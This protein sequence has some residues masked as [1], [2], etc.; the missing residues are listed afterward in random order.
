MQ[1]DALE[2]RVLVLPPTKADGDVTLR[3]LAEAGVTASVCETAQDMG[4]ELRRG[5]GALII[6]DDLSRQDPLAELRHL[7]DRQPSWSEI[8]ILVLARSD[9]PRLD[10][11]RG[12]RGVVLL[13]RPV[14][15]RSMVSA[16]QAALRP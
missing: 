11:L 4:R 7:L 9:F 8:P 6:T 12:V 16:V 10:E 5:A 2:T 13:E 14:H 3:V 15:L 1:L